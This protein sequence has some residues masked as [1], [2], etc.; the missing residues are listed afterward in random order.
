MIVVLLSKSQFPR[1][2]DLPAQFRAA[3]EAHRVVTCRAVRVWEERGHV[4]NQQR[5][6]L[7]VFFKGQ[8]D[9]HVVLVP[10]VE[11]IVGKLMRL[12]RR[13]VEDLALRWIFHTLVFITMGT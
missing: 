6:S 2:V 1:D 12:K 4:R 11:G 10:H 9:D 3:G 5:A 13:V 7:E 8:R